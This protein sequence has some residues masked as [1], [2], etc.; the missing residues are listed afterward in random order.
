MDHGEGR[1]DNVFQNIGSKNNH[2]D[3][4][5]LSHGGS[6]MYRLPVFPSPAAAAEDPGS[7]GAT[8]DGAS[9]A[10][11]SASLALAIAAQETD[12]E[13]NVGA[14]WHDWYPNPGDT[15]DVSNASANTTVHITKAGEYRLTGS[16][17]Q[18]RVEVTAPEGQTITIKLADRLN[19]DPGI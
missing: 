10:L 6:F 2:N 12:E 5:C 19:I 13:R 8:V 17:T 11:S 4:G 3:T 7:T 14:S 1:R 16:S 15:I 9:S 18:V